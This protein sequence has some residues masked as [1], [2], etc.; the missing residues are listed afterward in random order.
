[1]MAIS[2]NLYWLFYIFVIAI[3]IPYFAVTARRLHDQNLSG[4]FQLLPFPFSI[5]ER[6]SATFSE[7]L[8]ILLFIISLS[9][10]VYLIV[11]FCKD[12][13][14]KDNRFGKNIYKKGKKRR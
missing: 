3:I 6:V 8:E 7:D 12:G 4:W 5:L 13:D 1:M 11:L 10:Y 2:F 14:K 9:L